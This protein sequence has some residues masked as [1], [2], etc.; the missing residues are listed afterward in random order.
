MNE[1]R[2][3]RL[4]EIGGC[5]PI[6]I[7][8][9]IIEK[10][11]GVQVMVLNDVIFAKYDNNPYYW[12]PKMKTAQSLSKTVRWNFNNSPIFGN[13]NNFMQLLGLHREN[14]NSCE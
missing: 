7:E 4:Q 8:K 12:Q 6:D 5:F 14:A 1:N 2:Y 10:I 3:K 11:G 9:F 13:T